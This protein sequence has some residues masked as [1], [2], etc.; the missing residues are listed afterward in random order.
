MSTFLLGGFWGDTW[1]YRNQFFPQFELIWSNILSNL[2]ALNILNP[3]TPFR[4]ESFD[5]GEMTQ[6]VQPPNDLNLQVGE[7]PVITFFTFNQYPAFGEVTRDTHGRCSVAWSD[8]GQHA[9]KD[10]PL[11][12]VNAELM[13]RQP[14]EVTQEPPSAHPRLYGANSDWLAS[15][16][17]PFFDAPCEVG[18]EHNVGWFGGSGVADVKAHFEYSAR[19]FRSCHEA[20]K[21]GGDISSYGPARKY[22][23]FD[24]QQLPS[25]TDGLKVMH[26]VR[27]L[28]ACAAKNSGSFV[29][30]EYN[31]TE[32]ERL[33]QSLATVDLHRFNQTTWY[34]GVS[35]GGAVGEVLFDLTTSE[36]VNYFST[37]Y[38]LLVNRPDLLGQQD[39]S[40]VATSLKQQIGIFMSNFNTGHWNLW[41]GNNWTPHLCIAAMSWLVSFW[42]EEPSMAKDVMAMINDILWLH[43]NMFT[44]DGVYVEG[45]AMY[46]FMSITGLVGISAM[47]R[48]SFGFVPNAV[49]ADALAKLVEYHLASMSTDAYTVP[50]GDSHKKR[51]W[52][53]FS[54][55][56]A[57]VASEIIG[58]PATSTLSPCGAKEYSASL[59]GSGGLYED[60]WRI[61][62]ELL[63]LNLTKLVASCNAAA[64]QPL[65]G[66]IQRIFSE[67]GY[68]S[69]RIPLLPPGDT[70][71]CFGSGNS[72]LCVKNK[73]SLADN[74]PYS[75]LALQARPNSYPH[76][77]VD[78]GTFTWSAWGVR[79]ISEY[80]YGTI[81]T[82]VGEWDFRRY[83]YIDN[84]PAGHNTVVIREAF[85][86]DTI[87][88]SQLHRAVG[89][90]AAVDISGSQ[91]VELDGSVPYGAA[92][93][94]GWLE[95]MR[96]YACPMSDGSFVLMDVL[97]VKKDRS[98]LNL[99]LGIGL[100]EVFKFVSDWDAKGVQ[101][102][103][104]VF[105]W[106]SHIV[107]IFVRQ[108]TNTAELKPGME[109]SMEVPTSTKRSPQVNS[110]TWKNISTPK[111]VLP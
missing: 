69:M 52:G 106:Y 22:L 74:I 93:P 27:R 40:R 101:V 84:N 94:D 25:Y 17:E 11:M 91:C 67:G 31:E 35:C 81:A 104:T 37:W 95:I 66:T 26:L 14:L 102:V 54:T 110:C 56:Q 65:G 61:S 59:Y 105:C 55:L 39:A 4:G 62:P 53:D 47:Q 8:E 64:T 32:A 33:A 5:A 85:D 42:H 63:T 96:R 77:E 21:D 79:L 109:L 50:F 86:G 20:S 44:S 88:L 73:P 92:R 24:G 111:P 103:W 23:Q 6:I 80:G 41:N 78:F 29:S 7:H 13:Y 19:G 46:S 87:N 72:E 82:A 107:V 16:V 100:A 43:R 99:F 51:G 9:F 68:A 12:I 49:D 36:P 60:P 76:S 75:F 15:R 97:Q 48:A 58:R 10:K 83:K 38:D 28:W 3:A 89:T 90:I 34:C 98:K 2:Q 1:R 45:V 70:L 57:A 18:A 71:P 108:A 30:C